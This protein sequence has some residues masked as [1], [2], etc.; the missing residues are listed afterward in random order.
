MS[1]NGHTSHPR[2]KE[3]KTRLPQRETLSL[4]REGRW[5]SPTPR[6]PGTPD[7]PG[8]WVPTPLGS[9]YA[10]RR[11]FLSSMGTADQ[12]RTEKESSWGSRNKLWKLHVLLICEL[13]S[14]TCLGGQA[15]SQPR[16]AQTP[17]KPPSLAP[18][19]GLG[20]WDPGI[21]LSDSINTWWGRAGRGREVTTP[22]VGATAQHDDGYL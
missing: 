4:L 12:A 6:A 2:S 17:L 18:D 22:E 3:G 9:A 13:S 15:A 7:I 1:S 5:H 21:T 19:Q 10:S 20:G 16:P 8:T 11:Y 14:R